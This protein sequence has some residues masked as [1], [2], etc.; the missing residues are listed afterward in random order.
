MTPPN[1]R[2]VR[3]NRA[4]LTASLTAAVAPVNDTTKM[5]ST[6]TSTSRG[7]SWQ[8]EAWRFTKVIGELGYFVRWR[9]NACAQVRF[10]ASE[11]DEDTGLPTGSVDPGN[12]E[13]QLVV[14]LVK[15]MA[16]GP[17]GQKRLIKRAAACLT[18]PGELWICIL[19]R[20]DGERW[21]AVS[22]KEIRQSDKYVNQ[23]DGTRGPTVAIQ[24]PDGTMH[25]Y[26]PT[27]D[28]MFR[29][30]NESFDDASDADSP[31]RACLNSLGEIERA[32]KKIRNADRSRL[33]NNGL[34]MVPSE[35]S[36][37]DSASD[38][39]TSPTA[40]RRVAASLQRMLVQAA[41]VSDRDENSMASVLPIVGAAPGE[42]LGKI[43]HI[44]FAKEA[45]KTAVDIRNDAIARLAMGLDMTPERLLGMGQNSNHWSAY[46]LA[47]EDVKAHINPVMEVLCEAIYEATFVQILTGLGVDSSKYT[48]WF[49]SSRLTAD[50]DLTDEAKDA[51]TA[52]TITSSALVTHLGLPEDSQYDWTTE[53]GLAE[54]ARDRISEDPNLIKTLAVLVPELEGYEFTQPV[55]DAL[56]NY[57]PFADPNAPLP[58]Q[59]MQPGDQTPAQPGQ[60]E[61]ATQDNQ[62]TEPTYSAVEDV[63]VNRALELAAKRRIHTSDRQAHARLRHVP[64]HERNRHLPPVTPTEVAKLTH[65]WDDLLTPQFAKA[66]GLDADRLRAAVQ[67]RVTAELTG[68]SVNAHTLNGAGR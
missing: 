58:D 3:R 23:L 17:L 22:K 24:L 18:V 55:P 6:S 52:R 45:T 33:L 63:L 2:V 25:D 30:W 62:P 41:E 34:L 28:A 60:Q 29:V 48:L 49:D 59:P 21:Y 16:G 64:P 66:R 26:E 1:L 42:H 4:P 15:Q 56:A 31:V 7:T 10:V 5:F 32:T 57:D 35:A 12:D 13:G 20:P 19:Q 14:D 46:L 40:V 44:E 27:Q 43:A 47:D 50:P 53:E 68:T 65:G 51:Y 36:L 67:K 38:P 39:G 61:P 37:P 11:I 8:D 9:S 54:W